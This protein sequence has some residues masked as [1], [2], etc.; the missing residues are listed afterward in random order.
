MKRIAIERRD[1]ITREDYERDFAADGGRPVILTRA[2]DAWPARAK[3]SLDWFA[4]QFG[5]DLTSAIPDFSSDSAL[6]C[7]LGAYLEYL[8]TGTAPAGVWTS[9][10]TRRPVVPPSGWERKPLYM[11]GW[12]ALQQHPELQRDLEPHPAFAED[13]VLRLPPDQR[14]EFEEHCPRFWAVFIGPAGTVTTLHRDFGNTHSWLAQIEGRKR[15]LLFSPDDAPRLYDGAVDPERPDL[16]RFPE[17]A[18]A[19]AWEGEFGPGE[20]LLTPGGWWHHVRG[21]TTS[22]TVSH[23]FFDG[24]NV[25]SFIDYLVRAREQA[26]P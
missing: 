4:A 1:S 20:L 12:H 10:T 11:M 23:N 21:L 18:Q 24:Q 15:A 3:W 22:I 16:T 14:A 13:W 5:S 25:G 9:V 6:V 19:V 8:R 2:I 7:R 26:R 17:F